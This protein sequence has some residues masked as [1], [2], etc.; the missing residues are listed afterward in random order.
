MTVSNVLTLACAR[1]WVANTPG[2]TLDRAFG[3]ILTIGIVVARQ[4]YALQ[5]GPVGL[6]ASTG[7]SFTFGMQPE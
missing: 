4:T 5:T 2:R 3:A 6:S 7:P 1:G